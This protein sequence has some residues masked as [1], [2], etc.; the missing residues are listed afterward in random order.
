M[1]FRSDKSAVETTVVVDD[2]QMMVLGGLMKDEYT[3]S[4]GRV[5]GLSSVPVLGN[6]FRNDSRSRVKSNLMIFLRPVVVRDQ[7][8][9]D[10]LAMDRYEAIRANQRDGQ[11]ERTLLSPI[12]ESPVLPA[13][14]GTAPAAPAAVPAPV[15]Q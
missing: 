5:P 9:S 10:R 15:G 11:P 14:P 6:L 3:D 2:G 13:L 4:D 8:T 12:N 7:A 1:L